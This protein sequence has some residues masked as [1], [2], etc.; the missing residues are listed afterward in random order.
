MWSFAPTPTAQAP[1]LPARSLPE[2]VVSPLITTSAFGSSA[3]DLPGQLVI[4]LA[5]PVPLGCTSGGSS[6][7]VRSSG[8]SPPMHSPE[9]LVWQLS[10]DLP[11]DLQSF[12]PWARSAQRQKT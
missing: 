7:F 8:I 2:P 1:V 10:K 9:S 3:V 5:A 12:V 4:V 6:S 11:S